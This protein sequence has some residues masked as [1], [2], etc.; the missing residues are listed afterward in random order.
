MRLPGVHESEGTV[1]RG[2]R[3]G[4]VPIRTTGIV[5]R[6]NIIRECKT[7]GMTRHV[8]NY[9]ELPSPAQG[10]RAEFH[11]RGLNKQPAEGTTRLKGET[12]GT[13]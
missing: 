13:P 4:E 2:K 5:R 11:L 3:G 9:S 8:L 1:G 12:Y 7:E 10:S 6:A